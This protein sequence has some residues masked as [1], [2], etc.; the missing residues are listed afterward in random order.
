MVALHDMELVAVRR[1]K[2]VDEGACVLSDG[3]D[4][5][6]LAFVMPDRFSVPGW[7]RVLRVWNIQVDMAHG[8]IALADGEHFLGRLYEEN[9]LHNT[10]H[11]DGH[12]GRPAARGPRV[13]RETA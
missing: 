6:P 9:R 4:H 2:I 13:H 12:S 1:A 8:L 11:S 3:I 7:F 10:I 5:Q